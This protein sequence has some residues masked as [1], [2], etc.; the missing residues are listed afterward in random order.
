[1]S[2]TGPWKGPRA[3]QR[4]LAR[5]PSSVKVATLRPGQRSGQDPKCA[6]PADAENGTERR[7]HSERPTSSGW[8]GLGLVVGVAGSAMADAGR[9]ALRRMNRGHRQSGLYFRSSAQLA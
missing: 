9:P 4:P 6:P 8:A 5:D 7:Y 1:M 3:C 2:E